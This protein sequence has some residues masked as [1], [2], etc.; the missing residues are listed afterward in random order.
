MSN[1]VFVQ[2]TDLPWIISSETIT[3]SYNS[4]WS[5]ATNSANTPY[6]L[7]NNITVDPKITILGSKVILA[8]DSPLINMGITAA[9]LRD[10]YGKM[11]GTTVGAVQE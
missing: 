11:R 4:F 3:G 7:D 6:S 8:T 1:N 2:T 9:S 10:V 5:T